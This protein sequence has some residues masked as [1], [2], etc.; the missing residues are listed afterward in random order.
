LRELREI[1]GATLPMEEGILDSVAIANVKLYNI[2]VCIYKFD[3][4]SNVPD[5]VRNRDAKTQEQMTYF[6]ESTSL[7][8]GYPVMFLLGKIII[9]FENKTLSLPDDNYA[10]DNSHKE[11]NFFVYGNGLYTRLAVNDIPLTVHADFGSGWYMQIH[12]SFYEKNRD[13]IPVKALGEKKFIETV[14][15]HKTWLDIPY[16]IPENPVLKFNDRI[17]CPSPNEDD[18][19][20]IY[21]LPDQHLPGTFDGHIGYPFFKNLGKKILFDFNNMRIEVVE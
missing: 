2:P 12:S 8:M 6:S 10:L 5:S 11:P 18:L 1:N 13:R 14:M 4:T 9:D 19:I 21:S 20:Q 15:L 3:P 17:I 16:E 7:V